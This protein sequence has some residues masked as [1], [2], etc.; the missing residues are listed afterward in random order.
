ME[1]ICKA[2]VMLGMLE[3]WPKNGTAMCASG[4]RTTIKHAAFN[5]WLWELQTGIQDWLAVCLVSLKLHE[6][7]ANIN[8]VVG[9]MD[10][11]QCSRV[12]EVR[13]G[14]NQNKSARSTHLAEP[15]R[16]LLMLFQS[17]AN[18]RSVFSNKQ[19]SSFITVYLSIHSL[20]SV[21]RSLLTR[22]SSFSSQFV[23]K[24]FSLLDE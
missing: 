15:G 16:Q 9:R 24:T 19:S 6:A 1:C 23:S 3:Q 2:K 4:L 5:F 18:L 21:T 20:N 13:E 12:L 8:T 11:M 22:I 10:T 14:L 17:H 7:R